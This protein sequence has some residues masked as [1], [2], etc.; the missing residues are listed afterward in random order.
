MRKGENLVAV[1]KGGVNNAQTTDDH[2]VRMA[3]ERL[4]T[5]RIDDLVPYTNNARVH[6]QKQI[7]QI[8][9]SLREFGFVT[10]VLIDSDNN[11]IAGH[12]RVEAARAEGMTEVPCVLV[13]SLT[14]AQRKAY[15][16]ADNRLSEVSEWDPQLLKIEIKELEALHFD[17][18]IIGFDAQDVDQ[19]NIGAQTEP[20]ALDLDD[21]TADSKADNQ[22]MH[23]PKCGF[24]FEVS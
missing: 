15:I 7:G 19:I 21:F 16:L 24:V 18:Q 22:K 9:A 10:P 5:V 13:S 2:Q 14:E 11:I 23:C 4:L 17:V 20:D 12:G 3:T 6:T 1:G 8:R